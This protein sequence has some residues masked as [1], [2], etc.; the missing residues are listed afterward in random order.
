MAALIR[1]FMETAAHPQFRHSLLHSHMFHYHVVGDTSLLNPGVLPYYPQSFFFKQSNKHMKK[2][3]SM[4]RPW[5]PV[6]GL[7]YWQRMAWPW[8]RCPTR[9]PCSTDPATLRWHPLTMTGNLAGKCA[10]WEDW[11]V[12]WFP[13]ISSCFTAF[14]QS[15]TAFTKSLQQLLLHVPCAQTP[16]LR[17]CSMPSSAVLTM[18][19]QAKYLLAPSRGYSQLL[20]RKRSFSFSFL[21]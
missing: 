8:S 11:T 15:E 18:V 4:W 9:R 13:S 2:L 17:H 21:M 5:P 10:G 3:P 7:E 1:T 6:S 14:Y 16:A 20:P 19:A 12:K